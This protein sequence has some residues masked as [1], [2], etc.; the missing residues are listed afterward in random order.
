MRACGPR[1]VWACKYQGWAFPKGTGRQLAEVSEGR[2]IPR[3]TVDVDPG[4]G[5]PC[6]MQSA[7]E[8]GAVGQGREGPWA[9]CSGG[10]SLSGSGGELGGWGSM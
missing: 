4:G 7:A 9:R 1:R 2:S 6:L 10:R 3:W 5:G 8:W